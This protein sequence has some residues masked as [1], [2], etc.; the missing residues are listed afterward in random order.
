MGIFGLYWRVATGDFIWRKWEVNKYVHLVSPTFPI[1]GNPC[2]YAP[3]CLSE[4]VVL[5]A[6]HHFLSAFPHGD[7]NDKSAILGCVALSMLGVSSG[8]HHVF[9]GL[10]FGS[11]FFCFFQMRITLS[12]VIVL[13]LLGVIE[14]FL[15]EKVWRNTLFWNYSLWVNFIPKTWATVA[16][17]YFPNHFLYFLFQPRHFKS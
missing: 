11:L 12:A 16:L 17:P 3:R 9:C 4:C 7:L 15:W 1:F 6:C 14:V 2:S 10:E 5:L 13:L 8:R